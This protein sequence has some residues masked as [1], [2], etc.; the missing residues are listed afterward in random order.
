MNT[1]TMKFKNLHPNSAFTPAP[2]ERDAGKVFIKSPNGICKQMSNPD[3]EC[4]FWPEDSV[5]P[6]RIPH[7]NKRRG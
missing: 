5:T 7:H 4:I 6:V 2:G 1:K 3:N